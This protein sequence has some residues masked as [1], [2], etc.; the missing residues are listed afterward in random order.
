VGALPEQDLRYA[1][2]MWVTIF[3]ERVVVDLTGSLG[4]TPDEAADQMT[5]T[6]LS[7]LTGPVDPAVAGY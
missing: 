1:V 5:A 3:D 2:L 6:L 4:L 7:A